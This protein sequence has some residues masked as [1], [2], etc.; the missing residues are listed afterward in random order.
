MKKI[1]KKIR[2]ILSH[3]III[4]ILF[5]DKGTNPVLRYCEN[6]RKYKPEYLFKNDKD[7]CKVCM[8]VDESHALKIILTEICR[9]SDLNY[10]DILENSRTRKREY[11]QAR[12]EFHYF[13]KEL[14]A[15]S[16]VKIGELV[17]DK[18]H[19]TVMH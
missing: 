9:E 1:L 11:V 7:I 15:F 18:D 4:N 16:L 17:G 12:Q 14:T 3:K 13:L 6:C 5:V 10:N 2:K 19:A 8:G